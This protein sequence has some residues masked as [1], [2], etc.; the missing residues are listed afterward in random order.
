MKNRY[1]KS[2]GILTDEGFEAK[3][4]K[5]HAGHDGCAG[6]NANIYLK[7]R[8]VMEVYDSAHGGGLEMRS[9]HMHEMIQ[10]PDPD[11]PGKMKW[12]RP[13]EAIEKMKEYET[14]LNR[15]KELLPDYTWAEEGHGQ[16]LYPDSLVNWDEEGMYNAIIEIASQKKR[17]KGLLKQNILYVSEGELQSGCF[18]RGGK[19]VPITPDHIERWK[20]ETVIT[21]PPR[22]NVGLDIIILN[23]KTLPE[24]LLLWM[25][26]AK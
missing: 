1:I 11:K 7:G 20:K 10:I 9:A 14:E 18:K 23:E 24:A 21:G 8:K 2:L 12:H 6:V 19:K 17:L 3:A 26:Y 16:E 13:E 25:E 4:V 22:R 5:Y 15:I